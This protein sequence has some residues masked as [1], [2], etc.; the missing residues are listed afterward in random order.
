[1]R[2]EHGWETFSFIILLVS[3]K[4]KIFIFQTGTVEKKKSSSFFALKINKKGE[5]MQI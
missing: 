3:K 4:W 2:G 5:N 1:M